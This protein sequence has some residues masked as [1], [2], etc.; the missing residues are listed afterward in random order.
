MACYTLAVSAVDALIDKKKTTLAARW[1][2]FIWPLSYYP[3]T[4]MLGSDK[5]A[6]WA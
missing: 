1:V 3:S 6:D 2:V 5:A 4:A